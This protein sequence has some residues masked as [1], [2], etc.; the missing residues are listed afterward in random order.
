MTTETTTHPSALFRGLRAW[1][2]LVGLSFRR[3]LWSVSTL[4]LAFPL[5]GTAV[6]AFWLG[7]RTQRQEAQEAFLEF[8]NG[9]VI[10]LFTLVL[11]PICA[12]SYGTSSIG[13]DREDRTLLFL[14]VRPI[15]RWAILLAKVTATLPL[16]LG[17]ISACFYLYCREAGAVGRQA[18]QLYFPA[19][20]S[21]AAAYVGVYHLFAVMFRH[22]TT[23]AL[24]YS[25][26]AESLLGNM[27]GVTK[28]IAVNFY[29]RCIMYKTAEPWGLE[30]PGNFDP[31]SI[32]T[33]Y[34]T[35]WGIAVGSTLLAMLIF[36]RREYRDLT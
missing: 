7:L 5:A 10:I 34:I 26:F 36:S 20:F 6:L 24:I 4:T 12:L 8:S 21:M 17:L 1:F 3:L 31:V 23:V 11:L 28:R 29:G 33:A 13:G 25:L 27:P 30:Q 2:T 22:S 14:L 18:F 32:P 19:I 35:L 15:P 9:F 16:V